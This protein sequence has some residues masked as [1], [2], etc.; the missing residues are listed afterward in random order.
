MRRKMLTLPE[1]GD[2]WHLALHIKQFPCFPEKKKCNRQNYKAVKEMHNLSRL[3]LNRGHQGSK[4]NTATEREAVLI[5]LPSEAT[6]QL[7][8]TPG[9]NPAS[10]IELTYNQTPESLIEIRPVRNRPVACEYDEWL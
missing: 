5:V 8:V 1:R 2:T 6:N 4:S 3:I 10:H 9:S 7:T